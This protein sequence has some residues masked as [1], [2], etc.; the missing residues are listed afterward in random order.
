VSP[1]A[2]L[3]P[4]DIARFHRDDGAWQTTYKGHA[5]YYR[6]SELGTRDV[7][8]D[9]VDERWFVARDYVVF[10]SA[11]RKF[12]PAGGTTMD[13][14]FLTDSFGRTLYICLDDQPGTAISEAISSC[15]TSC[16]A[17]RPAFAAAETA[18]ITR[19]P[20]L[21][22]PSELVRADGLQ[23]LTYRGWPLYLYVG[24]VGAGSTEGH[25]DRAWRAID[26]VSFGLTDQ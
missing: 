24:D 25:N 13:S 5:L 17:K 16:S 22:D 12:T 4:T 26:P 20:S 9:G 21:L 6:A 1:S 3:D 23:Q 7:T 11:A 2:E 14:S 19:V 8:G 18:R 10:L 15:D